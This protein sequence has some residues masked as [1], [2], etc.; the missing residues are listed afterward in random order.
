MD[1][2]YLAGSAALTLYLAHRR[3]FSLDL[4]TASNRLAAADRRDLLQRL[5][6]LDPEARVETARDGY[7][8]A[9]TGRGVALRWF[10]YPYPLIESEREIDGVWVA[11]PLDLGLMKL[12]AIIS[13]GTRRDFAD[14]YLLCRAL[15]LEELIDRAPEKFGHVR[16]FPVQALKAL[17]DFSMASGGSLGQLSEPLDW[18]TV[19][20]WARNRSTELGRDRFDLPAVDGSD[21]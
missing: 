1:E 5:L 10:Y 4:M 17:T 8:Y 12:G 7:L 13:R 3:V 19:E 14:L 15:P 20:H 2:A 18:S 6:E 16:D 21:P 9:R 11:S